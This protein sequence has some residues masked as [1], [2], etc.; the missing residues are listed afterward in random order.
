MEDTKL[1]YE[2]DD[3]CS[4]CVHSRRK[5]PE[6]STPSGRNFGCACPERTDLQRRADEISI[7]TRQLGKT[8]GA[9]SMLL[10]LDRDERSL[11]ENGWIEPFHPGVRCPHYRG[12]LEPASDVV[13]LSETKGEGVTFQIISVTVPDQALR[14]R[15]SELEILPYV[16]V[17]VVSRNFGMYTLRIKDSVPVCVGEEI[18]REIL[19]RNRTLSSETH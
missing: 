14:K 2:K 6:K 17:T 5:P 9:T 15:L 12:E 11:A 4:G 19:V 16:P 1:R 10:G 18:A 8:E 7:L 3:P 13:P